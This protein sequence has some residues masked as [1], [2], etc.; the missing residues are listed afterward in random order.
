[1]SQII[2][3]AK[4]KSL[5]SF[6]LEDYREANQESVIDY[7]LDAKDMIGLSCLFPDNFSY[8]ADSKRGCN[9]IE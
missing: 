1:M 2:Q 7:G 8:L 4:E 5:S 3:I 9:A 6:P